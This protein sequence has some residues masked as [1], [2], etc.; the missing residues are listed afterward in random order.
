VVQ[1]SQQI[2][3]GLILMIA[4]HRSFKDLAGKMNAESKQVA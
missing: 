3:F 2:A 4:S 1:L